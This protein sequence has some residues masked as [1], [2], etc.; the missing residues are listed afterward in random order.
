[1][2]DIIQFPGNNG[3]IYSIKGNTRQSKYLWHV[4]FWP[5]TIA[6]SVLKMTHWLW[7]WFL[8]ILVILKFANMLNHWDTPDENAG[9]VFVYHLLITITLEVFVQKF[10]PITYLYKRK[11]LQA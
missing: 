10:N 9:W 8:S 4:W 11:Q 1:M 3:R 7:L 5:A 6:W 2:A